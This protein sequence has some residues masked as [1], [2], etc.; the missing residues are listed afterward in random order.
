MP[1]RLRLWA[2]VLQ[3]A[4]FLPLAAAATTYTVAPQ[5][6]ATANYTLIQNILN[7]LNPGDVVEFD[8]DAAVPFLLS[9]G[10]AITGCTDNVHVTQ[11]PA[12]KKTVMGTAAS[13]ILIRAKSGK[14]PV[15]VYQGSSNNI[16][17][18][19]RTQYLVIRGLHLTQQAGFEQPGIDGIKMYDSEH[20]TIEDCEVSYIGGVALNFKSALP[21]ALKPGIN[22][23]HVLRHNHLHHTSLATAEGIYLGCSNSADCLVHDV[24]VDQNW[25][26]HTGGTQG[27]GVEV[28]MPSY[29]VT[30]TDNV[31][32]ET[33]YPGIILYGYPAGQCIASEQ[34]NRVE[35]NVIFAGENSGMQIDG[36]AV[37]ANNA[38]YV[39][40]ILGP[41]TALAL[42]SQSMTGVEVHNNVFLGAVSAPAAVTYLTGDAADFVDPAAWD[43]W[44]AAGSTLINS[45]ATAWAAVA[46]AREPEI[47]VILSS[48]LA[49]VVVSS[50]R[51][52][53]SERRHHP[54]GSCSSCC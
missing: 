33:H 37:L 27:D 26:H 49:A 47:A 29:A 8:G 2:T 22:A 14:Q 35:R 3:V 46:A 34:R 51:M 1:V 23:Y 11:C 24:E 31:I 17:D 53:A 45:G 18:L 41:T 28:K 36:P 4:V 15:L 7:Q 30:I 21:T 9:H 13:P 48:S 5:G 54:K 19:Y 25:I 42:Y 38:S 50:A 40:G 52:T 16:L 12:A 44:P 20:I 6:T 10:L 43:F 39:L 32:H